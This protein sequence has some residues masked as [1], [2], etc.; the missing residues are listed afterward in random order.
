MAMVEIA[1]L[2]ISCS[3]LLVSKYNGVLVERTDAACQLDS[4]DQIDSDVA[5]LLAGSVQKRILNVLRRLIFH[6][7]SPCSVQIATATNGYRQ[8]PCN[9]LRNDTGLP[10]KFQP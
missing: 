1:C 9:Q 5:A 2:K 8:N 6:R 10:G 4:A 7:R 3:W